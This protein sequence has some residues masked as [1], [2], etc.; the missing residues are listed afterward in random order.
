MRL[1][2][3]LEPPSLSPLCIRAE[4]SSN[5]LESFISEALQAFHLLTIIDLFHAS[6]I[7]LLIRP[8]ITSSH[9]LY[10]RTRRAKPPGSLP[11]PQFNTA[12]AQAFYTTAQ[13]RMIARGTCM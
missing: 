7:Y 2:S 10:S 11:R 13:T 3:I 5:T 1:A 6:F 8:R 9:I 12:R 4:S